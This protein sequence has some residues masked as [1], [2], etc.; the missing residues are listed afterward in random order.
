MCF[1]QCLNIYF[2]LSSGI[3]LISKFL[4]YFHTQPTFFLSELVS[5]VGWK[6]EVFGLVFAS[7]FNNW[8]ITELWHP[9]VFVS[10]EHNSVP[11]CHLLRGNGTAIHEIFTLLRLIPRWNYRKNPVLKLE[12]QRITAQNMQVH[13]R[14]S[15]RFCPWTIFFKYWTGW[16][17][18]RSSLCPYYVYEYWVERCRLRS[19]S[20]DR[21]S[22]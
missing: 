6:R 17:D 12:F 1:L 19:A 18:L 3:K 21:N 7:L 15:W 9:V 8:C 16:P 20:G 5:N 13:L 11:L 4:M 2:Y 22:G 14:L 10:E